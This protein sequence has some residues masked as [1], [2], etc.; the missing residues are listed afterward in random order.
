MLLMH[1]NRYLLILTLTLTDSWFTY[2]LLQWTIQPAPTVHPEIF[3]IFHEIFHAKTIHEILH[4]YMRKLQ[5]IKCC[6]L[7]QTYLSS[8]SW[9]PNYRHHPSCHRTD[10]L[11]NCD[12]V[13]Q[14]QRGRHLLILPR[15]PIHY[16]VNSAQKSTFVSLR[17]VLYLYVNTKNP[18]IFLS[19]LLVLM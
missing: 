19:L 18:I 7:M 3:E 8:S 15:P 9:R 13:P 12:D 16:P 17:I 6:G 14:S 11:I 5:H 1:N 4:H 10:C 2:T